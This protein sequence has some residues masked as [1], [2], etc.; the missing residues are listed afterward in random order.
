MYRGGRSQSAG[1]RV[2]PD[3]LYLAFYKPYE[4]LAQFSREKLPDGGFSDKTTL[5]D[6]GFPEHVYPVG[7]LDFDSEGLLLLSDDGRLTSTLF[8]GAKPHPR[9]YL[10]QVENIPD[11]EA[12]KK[13]SQ[14]VIIQGKKTLP[15]RAELLDYEPELP[16]RG[17]A[18]RFRKNIPTAWLRLTLTQ[19]M[20]RQVRRMT[21]AVGCPTLRLVRHAI[22]QLT[23]DG[24]ALSP[25]QWRPLTPDEVSKVFI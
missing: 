3:R 4:V 6:F 10:V 22:G 12:L 20:N 11:S 1:F 7:R 19:G 21:A 9:S 25:G 16:E 15:A 24:L 2:A 23:L 8:E 18:I 14:G 13:L 5:A 17:K